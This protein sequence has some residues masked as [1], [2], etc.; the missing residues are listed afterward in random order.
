MKKVY[1][2]HTGIKIVILLFLL[3]SDLFSQT[4]FTAGNLVV[5]KV[6]DGVTASLGSGSYQEYVVEVTPAGSV[7]QTIAIPATASAGRC[8]ES[9]SATSD[10]D[11]N[12]SGDGKLL[13]FGG[14]DTTAGTGSVAS[15]SGIN[16]IICQVNN[17]GAV[18]FPASYSGNNAS[19]NALYVGNN[20][21]SVIT[22]D[23]TGYWSCGAGT[24]GGIDYIPSGTMNATTASAGVAQLNTSLANGRVVKIFKGQLYGNASSGS[25]KDPFTIGTGLPITSSQTYTVLFGL[26]NSGHDGYSFVMFDRNGDGT[27][28]LLYIA[29][30]SSGL[31]KYYANGAI[32][33]PEGQLT[34][35]S[36]DATTGITGYLDCNNNPVLFITSGSGASGK[37]TNNKIYTY[38]DA[39]SNS[40]SISGSLPTV[41]TVIL[42]AGTG[43]IFRG[44]ALAPTQGDLNVSTATN[45]SGNY[46]NI[47]VNSNTLTLTG[48]VKVS[49]SIYVASGATLDCGNF[50]VSGKRFILASGATIKMGSVNGIT[51]SAALGN[52]QTTCRAYSSGANY[53]YTG[54]A[55]QVTGDGLPS[56]VNNLTI[57]NSSAAGVQLTNTVAVSNQLLFSSG[58]LTSTSSALL[59]MNAG[60]S[61]IGAN[62]SRYVNGPVRK[63]GNTAFNFP[64][65]K[66]G[67][68]APISISAPAVNTDHF[69]AEYF[70]SNPD[71]TYDRTM[72]DPT[73]D[74]ISLCEYW[75]LNRTGGS[76]NVS[77][78]LSWDTPRSCGV[79]LP[80]DL[81]VA[82]WNGSQWKDNGNG[83]TT[84]TALSGT[85]VS[86]SAASIFGPFTLSSATVINPLP[87]ELINF[88][89][90][91][92]E[93]NTVDLQWTTATEINNDYFTIERSADAN[94]F[95]EL[96][97][98]NGAGNSTHVLNYSSVDDT[99]LKGTSYYR[100]RQT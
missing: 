22:N 80:S 12:T 27:P 66:G 99:P 70:N 3:N 74:H 59:I 18:S 41:A 35:P 34:V 20:F 6:G 42:S 39:T 52:I 46:R 9:G 76:S 25:F 61:A 90:T 100:L 86:S 21:R 96:S 23:G 92:N 95:T 7:V 45:A 55:S 16:R 38:T 40:T 97:K 2:L 26:P 14:Y 60:S 71:P 54:N 91:L 68:Y 31:W 57:N 88:S 64:V 81:L 32:W 83:G 94:N 47:V 33:T 93:N 51:A 65:G 84:G 11:L 89:A 63:I 36:T 82:G 10:G 78:T 67:L 62:S 49:D 69:T 29:D 44:I 1:P 72:K 28:D 30:N 75:M 48:N 4:T 8:V 77:V 87:I 79:V 85:I 73:I 98:T 56:T 24:R 13:T 17:S 43:Y 53:E 58:I 19:S 50:I 5:L 15:A 37:T